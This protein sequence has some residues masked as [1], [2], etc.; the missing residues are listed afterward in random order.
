MTA[1]VINLAE[2]RKRRSQTPPESLFA[3]LD[4]DFPRED[5]ARL[6]AVFARFG[7][8]VGPDTRGE[9]L[10]DIWNWLTGQMGRH[11]TMLVCTPDIFGTVTRGYGAQYA[12]YLHAVLRDER[13][14]VRRLATELRILDSIRSVA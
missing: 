1:N 12:R 9:R 3:L 14:T 5:A 2:A 4:G 6:Q 7:L 13:E 11:L 8:E 10:V